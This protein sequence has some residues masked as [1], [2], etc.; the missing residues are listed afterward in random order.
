MVNARE[1]KY[2][3]VIFITICI[4]I[5]IVCLLPM[6]TILARSVSSPEYLIRNQVTLWPRVLLSMRTDMC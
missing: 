4:F 1:S 5:I 6:V 2:L 3:D